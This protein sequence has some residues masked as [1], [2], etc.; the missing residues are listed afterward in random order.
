MK[1]R[2]IALFISMLVMPPC[3]S[4]QDEAT[5]PEEIIVT[6]QRSV[7]NLRLDMWNAE[8][9]AYE[10]FN[11][12]NDEPRFDIHCSAHQIVGTR[13]ERQLCQPEFEIQAQA[14]HGREFLDSYRA[15]LAPLYTG[16]GNPVSAGGQPPTDGTSQGVPAAVEIAAQQ[17]DYRAKMKQVAEEHPEFLDALVRYSEARQ[18]YEAVT[19]TGGNAE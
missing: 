9:A 13:L 3:A 7:L 15:F 2:L 17:E 1:Q 11:A 19:S 8:R 6:G 5:P 4:A 12:F 14:R 10:T 16:S 18:R